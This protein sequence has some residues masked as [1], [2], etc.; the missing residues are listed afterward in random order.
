MVMSQQTICPGSGTAL[1]M[2]S[3]GRGMCTYCNAHLDTPNGW[4]P[5]HPPASDW[6]N[7]RATGETP[8][9]HCPGCTCGQ[10]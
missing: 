9:H 3:V 2:T 4:A 10:P 5:E 8:L 6:T 1:T 7:Y